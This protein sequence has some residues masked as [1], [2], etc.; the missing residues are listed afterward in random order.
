MEVLN[1]KTNPHQKHLKLKEY[2]TAP[3]WG[4]V[5]LE[6]AIPVILWV[7]VIGPFN[8]AVSKPIS[9]G[10][11]KLAFNTALE[12]VNRMI[13][14]GNAFTEGLS[15]ALDKYPVVEDGALEDNTKQALDRIAD[16][17]WC[18]APARMKRQVAVTTVKS[19]NECKLKLERDWEIMG[20]LDVSDD[21]VM[22]WSQRRI[23]ASFAFLKCCARRFETMRSENI[24]VLARARQNH[25]SSWIAYDLDKI[26]DRSVK[27]AYYERM[28]MYEHDFTLEE[29]VESFTD[30]L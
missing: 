10:Q 5:R 14:A 7:T 21:L 13:S 24:Q 20:A 18:V 3:Q 4:Q 1:E 8:T 27:K 22:E 17:H 23:E 15:M 16:E 6:L 11:I 29:A 19:L 30:A 25:V 9:Y 26:S 28:E 12:A 2:M